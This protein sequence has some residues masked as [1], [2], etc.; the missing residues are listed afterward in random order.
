VKM[1]AH[2]PPEAVRPAFRGRRAFLVPDRGLPELAAEWKVAGDEI[3][4]PAVK[5]SPPDGTGS[6]EEPGW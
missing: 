5:R 3:G 2:P 4:N 1:A 6:S